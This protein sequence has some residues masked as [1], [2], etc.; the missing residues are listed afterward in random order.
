V[1]VYRGCAAFYEVEDSGGEFGGCAVS[2][3][4]STILV[5][6]LNCISGVWR[7]PRGRGRRG[8]IM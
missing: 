4:Y 6:R 2:A 8:V 7:G 1:A 3:R 5:E